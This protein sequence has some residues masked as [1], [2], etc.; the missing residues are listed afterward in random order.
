MQHESVNKRK[1]TRYPV[2]TQAI[3]ERKT[4]EQLSAATLNISGSGMLVN[5]AR[6]PDLRLGEE[7]LCSVLL[8]QDKP[9]QSWGLGTV[10]RVEGSLVAIEFK[11]VSL[12]PD[13]A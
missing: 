1:E 12:A 4:G 3:L 9:L 6:A 2:D 7:L 13:L 5:L 8:Y 10:R 11:S